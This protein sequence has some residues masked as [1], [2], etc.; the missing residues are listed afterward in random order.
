MAKPV[1]VVEVLRREI[2]NAGC[3]GPKASDARAKRLRQVE[4]AVAELIAA[5]EAR[6]AARIASLADTRARLE[7][8]RAGLP[9]PDSRAA[10]AAAR[11]AD[12]RYFA[13]LAAC[14][15]EA[16]HG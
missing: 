6:D 11:D 7:A 13:A 1:D 12:D 10:W 8:R 5:C 4:D 15:P 9:E 14:K 2:E 3:L 16:S